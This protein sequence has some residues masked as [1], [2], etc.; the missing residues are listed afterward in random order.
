MGRYLVC[1][2]DRY[3]EYSTIVDAPVTAPMTKDELFEYVRREKGESGLWQLPERLRRVEERGHS[4][5]APYANASVCCVLAGN[6]AG[7]NYSSWSL[8]QF[9]AWC[10]GETVDV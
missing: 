7:P 4:A 10:R 6:R 9:K 2:E 8:E 5:S 3:F 1:L